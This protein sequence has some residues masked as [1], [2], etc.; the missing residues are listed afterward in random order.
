MLCLVYLTDLNDRLKL[1]GK[2]YIQTIS[3]QETNNAK[4]YSSS[5]TSWK[6]TFTIQNWKP[7]CVNSFPNLR[8]H[9]HFIT[10]FN[11]TLLKHNCSTK[12]RGILQKN[13]TPLTLILL[14]YH[15]INRYYHYKTLHITSSVNAIKNIHHYPMIYPN[16]SFSS[17]I[18][19]I[20]TSFV[21]AH[22]VN[23]NL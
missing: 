13:N 14:L 21:K 19:G 23:I 22:L 7:Y 2:Y 8:P 9:Y 3:I 10:H 4:M 6:M 5:L 20:P 12:Y 11:A 15:E 16:V 1:T 18:L 17:L